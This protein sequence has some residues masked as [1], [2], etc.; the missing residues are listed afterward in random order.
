MKSF[1]KQIYD[2]IR[3]FLYDCDAY[4]ITYQG[5]IEVQNDINKYV[6]ED[7]VVQGF[8]IIKY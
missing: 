2:S 4:H 5:N 3:V 7:H 6:M 1:Q 8:L